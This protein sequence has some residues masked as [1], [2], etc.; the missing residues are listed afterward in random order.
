MTRLRMLQLHVGTPPADVTERSVIFH[1]GR[2]DMEQ[3][4][5]QSQT[6]LAGSYSDKTPCYI[7]FKGPDSMGNLAPSVVVHQSS[8]Q[9]TGAL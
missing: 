1:S 2:Q 9:S 3:Q 7:H 8:F 4:E 5:G 6:G